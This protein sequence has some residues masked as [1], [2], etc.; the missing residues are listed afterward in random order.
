VVSGKDKKIWREHYY[1][2][3]INNEFVLVKREPRVR[4]PYLS[5]GNARVSCSTELMVLE[6]CEYIW[7]SVH[8]RCRP[9]LENG[10][11]SLH[12]ILFI[13]PRTVTYQGNEHKN[14]P[15]ANAHVFKLRYSCIRV[16]EIRRH[17]TNSTVQS[18][19]RKAYN[20]SAVQKIHGH[21]RNQTN[22]SE[23]GLIVKWI[24]VKT[25]VLTESFV[26]DIICE[27]T[28]HCK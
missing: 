14:K 17:S 8:I 4:G 25:D 24:F 21:Y 16:D 7:Q 19:S 28:E 12:Q 18:L 20:F 6:K 27:F 11:S 22:H 3:S 5:Y 2:N 9:Q 15:T 23:I 13:F 10:W 1:L 26:V